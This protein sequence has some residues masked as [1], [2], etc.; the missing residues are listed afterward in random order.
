MLVNSD[1]NEIFCDAGQVLQV[2]S[3]LILHL[4]TRALHG[5]YKNMECYSV[6]I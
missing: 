4:A 5:H 2:C 6:H 3:T 1:V